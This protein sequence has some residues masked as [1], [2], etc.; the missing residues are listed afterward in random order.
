MY[1]SYFIIAWRNI[2]RNKGYTA[3]N[4]LGLSIGI[5]ACILIAL[6]VQ[7]ELSYDRFN[8]K[9]DRVYRVN[10]EIK[11]GDNHLDLAV[12]YERNIR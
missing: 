7:F 10:N 11:F 2:L 9:A 3:I 1:K 4:I 8:L 5:A 6:Y 12:S